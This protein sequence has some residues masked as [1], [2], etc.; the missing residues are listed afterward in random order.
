MTPTLARTAPWTIRTSAGERPKCDMMKTRVLNKY[1]HMYR[2]KG[3]QAHLCRHLRVRLRSRLDLFAS[4][5]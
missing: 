2:R 3:A 1:L 4:D 5:I